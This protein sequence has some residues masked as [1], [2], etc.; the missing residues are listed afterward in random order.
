MNDTNSPTPK[1]MSAVD[2]RLADFVVD[3]TDDREPSGGSSS[4]IDRGPQRAERV[5]SLGAG[6][7]PVAPLQIAGGDV[8]GRG[9]ARGCE[10]PT[11]S[12]ATL[13]VTRP[14]H[15]RQLRLVMDLVRLARESGSPGDGPITVV[16]GF[17]KMMGS[18][19]TCA[20][21]SAA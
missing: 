12:M 8:V 9:V 1:T 5:E 18:P 15:D 17:K 3:P 2:T 10:G 11:S 20:S 16:G 19:G 21:I 7:L 4:V 6:P 13:R 14:D